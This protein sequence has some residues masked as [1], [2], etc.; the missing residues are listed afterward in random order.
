MGLETSYGTLGI[1]RNVAAD[2]LNHIRQAK[3]RGQTAKRLCD[4]AEIRKETAR[5]LISDSERLKKVA[6][7]A[8]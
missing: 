1:T 6:R 5:D 7:D 3:T 2:N 4:E 8:R